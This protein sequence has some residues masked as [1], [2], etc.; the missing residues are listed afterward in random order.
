[1]ST[2]PKIYLTCP[3]CGGYNIVRDACARWSPEIGEW[4][5]SGVY[6]VMAC[7]D[8][9]DECYEAVQTETPP[10]EESALPPVAG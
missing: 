9:G 7:D 6:D 2:K 4:E 1:M 10:P 5:L 8:C 3:K